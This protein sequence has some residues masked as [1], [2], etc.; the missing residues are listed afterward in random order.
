MAARNLD[1][2]GPA[3]L[4]RAENAYRCPSGT[5]IPPVVRSH[6]DLEVCQD[7][8]LQFPT[9]S[10]PNPGAS[11]QPRRLKEEAAPHRFRLCEAP[12]LRILSSE[13]NLEASGPVEL[14]S[15]GS[16]ACPK[17]PII[18]PGRGGKA[19]GR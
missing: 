16:S 6:R 2:G 15:C 17:A 9:P 10:P 8:L 7:A 12:V 5:Q 18:E 13:G 3:R 11:T 14:G 4:G 19:P 1:P